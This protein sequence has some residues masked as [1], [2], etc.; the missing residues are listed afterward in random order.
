MQ[1]MWFKGA[2]ASI[3]VSVALAGLFGM[4][5]QAAKADTIFGSVDVNKIQAGYSK[6]SDMQS[7]IK[8]LNDD[9]SRRLKIQA[10]YD[11]L[12]LDQQQQLE[13]LLGKTTR[14]DDENAKVNALENESSH[15][16][17]ELATLQQKPQAQLTDED[18]A[19]MTALTSEHQA[20][21]QALQEINDEYQDQ[22]NAQRDKV[23]GDFADQIR[24]V[25]GQIAKEKGISVVFDSSVAIYTTNDI[26]DEV[27]ARLNK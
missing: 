17:Q 20:G 15:D 16:S 8:N 3:I 13:A 23:T 7:K 4:A 27:L 22:F 19:R 21:Q 9:F 25:I 14:T 12:T 2:K 1:H 6:L 5:P 24:T 26:T 11:M 10:G 18:K